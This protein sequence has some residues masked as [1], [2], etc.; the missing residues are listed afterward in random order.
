[1]GKIGHPFFFEMKAYIKIRR[2]G[3]MRG[4]NK[5]WWCGLARVE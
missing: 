3:D 4:P 5:P 1:M 2:Q